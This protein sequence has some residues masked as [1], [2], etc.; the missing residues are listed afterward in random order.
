M[1]W[2][3]LIGAVFFTFY[4]V[5]LFTVCRLKF[6]KGHTILASLESSCRSFG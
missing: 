6:E 2:D 5:C 1:W 3:W 4:V